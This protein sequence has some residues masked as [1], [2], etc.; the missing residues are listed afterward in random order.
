M[1]AF[2]YISGLG[3]HQILYDNPLR[4]EDFGLGIARFAFLDALLKHFDIRRVHFNKRCV[5]LSDLPG[6]PRIQVI[7][8]NDGSTYEAHLVIGAD[9]IKST[10]RSI[11]TGCTIDAHVAWSNTGAYRGLVQLHETKK[12]GVKIDLAAGFWCFMGPDKHIVTYPIQGGNIIN[13]VAFI[14]HGPE[15]IGKARLP[16]GEPWVTAAS[17]EELSAA[18]D[19]WG[20]QVHALLSCLKKPSRWSIC[21]VHPHLDSFIQGRVALIGDA[22]HAMLTHLGGG[23][24][25][26]LED[27]SLLARLLGAQET[28]VNNL[29]AVLRVYDDLRRPRSQQVSDMSVKAGQIYE[30]QGENGFTANGVTEDMTGIFNPIWHHRLEHD[31]EEGLRRVRQLGSASI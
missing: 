2:R 3:D 22:A 10:I 1:T 24:G 11:I 27:A 25:Q 23:A 16:P 5:G 4:P 20:N 21:V 7:T 30:A 12:A 14:T 8:F 19:G 26:G 13:I 9:G 18:Y 17:Q 6:N 31:I 29:E 28:N 15:P